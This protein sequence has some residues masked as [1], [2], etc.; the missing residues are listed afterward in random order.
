MRQCQPA[1]AR[2]PDGQPR[3]VRALPAD[4]ATAKSSRLAAA[5]IAAILSSGRG[6]FTKLVVTASAHHRPNCSSDGNSPRPSFSAAPKASQHGHRWP[7]CPAHA[8]PPPVAM[9]A[10][11]PFWCRGGGGIN[12][13]SPSH[14]N[15]SPERRATVVA[16]LERTPDGQAP[17]GQRHSGADRCQQCHG[18]A[19]Q[20]V[21]AKVLA[22]AGLSSSGLKSFY[23]RAT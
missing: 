11:G 22:A 14:I 15:N 4:R 6:L 18:R 23:D 1:P 2:P 16:P 10:S 5:H 8:D 17:H 20:P 9:P 12:E 7:P 3:T 21:L 19:C 13:R